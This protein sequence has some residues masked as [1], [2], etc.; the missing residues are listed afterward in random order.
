MK[1]SYGEGVANHIGP[2]SCVVVGN[3]RDNSLALPRP[4]RNPLSWRPVRPVSASSVSSGA[5]LPV[6]GRAADVGLRI[7]Q[8]WPETTTTSSGLYSE[9]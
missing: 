9:S 8:D 7:C 4:V 3:G 6:T 1:E 5:S 2:E